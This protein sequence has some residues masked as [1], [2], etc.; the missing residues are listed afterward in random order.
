MLYPTVASWPFDADLGSTLSYISPF[1]VSKCG[2]EQELLC[3]PFEVSK[4]MGESVIVR[5]MYRGCDVMIYDRHTLADLNELVEFDVI[6]GMDW[7]ASCYTIVDC[8]KK[9]ARFYFPGEPA[10]KSKGD[11][12]TPKGTFISYLRARKMITKG[13][14]YHLVGVREAEAKPLTIQSVQVVSEFPD[15]FPDELSSIPPEREIEFAIDAPPDMQPI[16][17]PPYRMAPTELMELKDQLKDLLD[18]D[19]DYRQ[20]N[21][22]TIKN[23]YPPLPRIDD[24]FEQLQGA[25]YFSKIDLRYGYHQL[26]VKGEDILK[27]N[28]RT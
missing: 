21:K 26:R 17:I 19:I 11:I 2:K 15:V 10:I 20:L 14:F 13:C 5:R 24:L 3:Q 27:T 6:I 16:L 8:W 18:K 28:F 7:L 25:K 23:K 22:V 9:V 4:P 12:A 1:V